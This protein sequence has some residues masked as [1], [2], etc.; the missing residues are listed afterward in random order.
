MMLYHINKHV[1]VLWNVR[2]LYIAHRPWICSWK[3][4]IYLHVRYVKTSAAAAKYMKSYFLQVVMDSGPQSNWLPGIVVNYLT[5]LFRAEVNLRAWKLQKHPWHIFM[6][7]PDLLLLLMEP[8]ASRRIRFWSSTDSQ[9][10]FWRNFCIPCLFVVFSM[11][12][13]HISLFPLTR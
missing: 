4:S 1:K 6:P 9:Q 8:Q 7:Q 10:A 11:R 2:I 3:R 12:T 5:R 13:S